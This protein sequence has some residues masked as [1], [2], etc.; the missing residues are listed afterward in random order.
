MDQTSTVHSVDTGFIYQQGRF[1]ERGALDHLSFWG[2]TLVWP[3]W[4]FV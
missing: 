1:R 3:I 2:P 4:P